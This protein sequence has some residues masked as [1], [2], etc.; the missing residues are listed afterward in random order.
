MTKPIP[1]IKSKSTISFFSEHGQTTFHETDRA[2]KVVENALLNKDWAEIKKRIDIE[3]NI[4]EY[5]D[6]RYEIKNGVVMI[7]G[8]TYSNYVT[9]RI[10]DMYYEGLDVNPI[11]KFLEKL[12]ENPSRRAVQELL[13]FLEYGNLPITE[14]GN[15]LAYKRVRKDYTDCHSGKFDNSV[16]Q[17]VS[18]PRNEVD[19]DPTRTC[20]A[21]LHVCSYEYLAAFYGERV[22][23]CEINPADVVAVPKDYNNTKMRVCRYK[24]VNEIAKFSEDNNQSELEDELVVEHLG[25]DELDEAYDINEIYE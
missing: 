22:V 14:A 7:D 24:V 15:F 19:D 1:F 8:Q 11:F 10:I 21:G 3:N 5:L 25:E 20:S 13:Q 4:M 17:V 18:M 2:F 6:G 16:G 9:Q 23:V 12:V